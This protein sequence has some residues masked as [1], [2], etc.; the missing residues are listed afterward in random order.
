MPMETWS[1]TGMGVSMRK[2]FLIFLLFFN[3]DFKQGIARM[4]C[5]T[6]YYPCNS[7][8]GVANG[9]I[10]YPEFVCS[11]K[12]E[13]SERALDCKGKTYSIQALKSIDKLIFPELT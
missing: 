12:C 1:Q 2:D 5:P 11:T 13:D 7:L 10:D 8:R 6:G 9:D 4:Q 3:F